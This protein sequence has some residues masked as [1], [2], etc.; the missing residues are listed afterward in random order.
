VEYDGFPVTG[1]TLYYVPGQIRGT[2]VNPEMLEVDPE[3]DRARY[4]YLNGNG[5][6]GFSLNTETEDM[7]VMHKLRTLKSVTENDMIVTQDKFSV[8]GDSL[9]WYS[10]GTA[11]LTNISL[12]EGYMIYLENGPDTLRVTG[13][14]QASPPDISLL[15]GWNWVGYPYDTDQAIDPVFDIN[16]MNGAIGTANG[17]D[18]ILR[19][20][21]QPDDP[22][23]DFADYD[24]GTDTWNGSLT[25]MKPY[26]LHKLFTADPNAANLTWTSANL[27]GEDNDAAARMTG[28]DPL[29]ASTWNVPNYGS[30]EIMPIIA[31]VEVAGQIM[32]DPADM[33]AFFYDDTLRGY[34][35]ITLIPELN[36]YALTIV[37]KQLPI[38]AVYDIKYYDASEG[39][40][41]TAINQL[42]FDKN[43]IGTLMDPYTLVFEESDCDNVLLLGPGGNPFAVDKTF[44]ARQSI[45]VL[46]TLNVPSGVEIILSAPQV[47]IEDQL[48][49]QSGSNVIIR[50]DGC[51]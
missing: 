36:T 27:R 5:W 19:N 14:L 7:E 43:G 21:G 31:D 51:N 2:A 29:D 33:V 46:G 18:K 22:S 28:V 24:I 1:D 48:D 25:E 6:T 3:K 47:I 49:T 10:F 16:N 11:E 50:P 17:S 37:G 42:G 26:D 40:I 12:D 4:I 44:E 32:T 45:R 39:V 34:G 30:E 41:M 13:A 35:E 8:Y 38:G 23:I 15:A 20:Y 9:G